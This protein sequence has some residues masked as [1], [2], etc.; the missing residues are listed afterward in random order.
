MRGETS[1]KMAQVQNEDRLKALSAAIKKKNQRRIIKMSTDDIISIVKEYQKI[2]PR[3]ID[4]CGIRDYLENTVI[5]I[6][7]DI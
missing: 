2:V 5:Y 4:Y 7:E 3:G 6:P 1:E